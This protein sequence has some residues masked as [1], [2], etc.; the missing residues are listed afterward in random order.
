M[1]HHLK[2][3]GMTDFSNNPST[4]HTPTADFSRW[5]DPR[6]AIGKVNG[7]GSFHEVLRDA[8][9][10]QTTVND[11]AHEF[12]GKVGGSEHYGAIDK[13]AKAGG[14]NQRGPKE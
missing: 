1:D 2:S 13:M 7:V 8:P 10:I 11:G 14:V 12:S 6:E 5:R 9:P 3:F 4:S